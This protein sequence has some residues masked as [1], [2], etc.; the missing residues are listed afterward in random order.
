MSPKALPGKDQDSEEEDTG[1]DLALGESGEE[2]RTPQKGKKRIVAAKSRIGSGAE[3]SGTQGLVTGPGLTGLGDPATV[4]TNPALFAMSTP[5]DE[6][7]PAAWQPFQTAASE[8]N[9]AEVRS[10]GFNGREESGGQG[11]HETRK[12]DEKE[13][14]LKEVRRAHDENARLRQEMSEFMRAMQQERQEAQYRER[15]REL[16]ERAERVRREEK[17]WREHQEKTE[18]EAKEKKEKEKDEER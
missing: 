15:M 12:V 2:F 17:E 13:E 1:R 6:E 14:L 11:A 5:R 7:E 18:R 16:D 4:L 9:G 8:A 3:S 10:E